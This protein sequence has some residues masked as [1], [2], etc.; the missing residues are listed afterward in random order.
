MI[1]APDINSVLNVAQYLHGIASYIRI[2]LQNLKGL[3]FV[4]NGVLYLNVSFLLY[5]LI[6]WSAI[7]FAT[8][9]VF[10]STNINTCLRSYF[11]IYIY[12][13]IDIEN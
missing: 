10:I 9:L 4:E 11:S 6:G 3:R 12:I 5:C 13:S 2:Y 7:T 1:I 8:A